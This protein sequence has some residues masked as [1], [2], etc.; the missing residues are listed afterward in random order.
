[1][2]KIFTFLI[3]LVFAS[4]FG[5]VQKLREFSKGNIIDSR[6]IFE[7]KSED[8]FGYFLLYEFDRQSREIYD[9]EYVILDNNLNKITSGI[10]TQS[11]YK[12]FLIKTGARLT[13]VKKIKNQI[14][15]GLHDNYDNDYYLSTQSVSDYFRER[16]RKID[17]DNFTVS[18]EFLFQNSKFL[19]NEVNNEDSM[20][21]QD[22]LQNQTIYPTNSEYFVMFDT[23]TYKTPSVLFGNTDY[24]SKIRASVKS[25]SVMDSNMNVVWSK[26]INSDK[27]NAGYYRVRTSNSTTLIMEKK[28]YNKKA[29]ELYEYEI[30]DLASGKFIGEI[31][32]QDPKYRI[33]PF[34]WEFSDDNIIVYNYLHELR[35]KY[36]NHEKA[37]GHARLIFDKKTGKELKRDYI[38]WK[39]LE[40]HLTFK[41]KFG[42]IRKY[43]KI[44]F[45]DFIN[46]K[47]GN[48]IGIAEGYKKAKYSKILDFYLMEFDKDMKIKYFQKI[49]KTPNVTKYNLSGRQ[50]YSHREFDFYYSQKLDDDD[51]YVILYSNNEKEGNSLKR[52]KKPSWVLGIITYVD[53]QFEVDKLQ[54]TTEDGLITPIMARNGSII[55]REYSEKN[56]VEMRLEKINY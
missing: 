46:L 20:R 35:D 36:Y 50:L 26:D 7:E 33:R 56:G 21:A 29:K 10:F 2:K 15:F 9:M 53:G 4:S 27:K 22:M 52:K 38:L 48:T 43:G 32:P 30:Y 13:F 42:D 1:M 40:P 45:Q 54:L 5:Q 12:N 8:V 39:D 3:T 37:L 34:K 14:F 55:L 51:N 23:P 31:I 16:Y 6:I 28:N 41:G 24:A 44:H 17:L 18:K 19:E 49:E 25:F 47:N 11:V